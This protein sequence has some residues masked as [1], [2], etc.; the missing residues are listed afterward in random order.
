[1]G[2]SFGFFLSIGGAAQISALFG[3]GKGE[4][5]GQLCADL[6]RLTFVMGAIVPAVILPIIKPCSRWFGADE[7]VT[8]LGMQYML[9]LS[10]GSICSILFITVCGFL[11][12]EGRTALYGIANFICL[13]LNGLA[14]DPLFLF[15]LKTSIYGVSLATIISEFLPA[16]AIVIQYYRGKFSI[17]PKLSQWCNKFSDRVL[18]TLKVG[19]S[20][21][22]SQLSVAIPSIIVRKLIGTFLGDDYGPAMAGM[23]ASIRITTFGFSVQAGIT[24]GFLPPASYAYAKKDY[25]RYL[26]L[27]WH[28]IWLPF[29]WGLLICILSLTIP[30]QLSMLFDNDAKYVH[31][32]A[33]MM[34]NTNC[35][36]MF[37]GIRFNCQTMLQSMQKG[38]NATVAGLLN[39]FVWIIGFAFLFYYTDKDRDACRLL[40]AYPLSHLM[41]LPCSMIFLWKPLRE[42]WREAKNQDQG[43]IDNEAELKDLDSKKQDETGM[44]QTEVQF[45]DQGENTP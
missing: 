32:S 2:R 15:G 29:V 36:L 18:P 45:S 31:Y 13:A 3:L 14:L 33:K 5:A 37:S 6:L 40:F 19:V 22:I 23:N 17:K 28:S 25:K 1:M 39:N 10:A 8:D 21:L 34:R 9:P 41:A 38:G 26:W 4:E 12:G 16:I 20:Q 11:Q 42:A 7:T 35:L 27:C 44:I 30:E 24:M 43:Q